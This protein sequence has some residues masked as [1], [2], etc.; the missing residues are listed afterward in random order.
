MLL[1]RV[2]PDLTFFKSGRSRILLKLVF[3]SQNNTPVIKL[4][5]STMLSAATES[6]QFSAALVV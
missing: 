5:P 4:M 1:I 6:V 2:S 3:G